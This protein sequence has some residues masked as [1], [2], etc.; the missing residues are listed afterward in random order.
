M[1]QN[2]PSLWPS[3]I[4][5]EPNLRTPTAILKEQA[6]FLAQM[7]KNLVQGQLKTNKQ[8][9][10]LEILLF[11]VVP[12]LQ[13]YMTSLLEVYHPVE[14]YPATVSSRALGAPRTAEDEGS[15]VA[16]VKEVLNSDYTKKL[17]RA[18]LAQARS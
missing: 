15:F 9:D 16:I 8:G 2:I 4:A 7:T 11:L 5:E 14:L 13:N 10:G 6:A 17:L 1:P 18:L 12:A 3:A